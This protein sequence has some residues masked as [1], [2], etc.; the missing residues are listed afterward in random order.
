MPYLA[1]IYGCLLHL[2]V[3]KYVSKVLVY[4]VSVLG[5]SL[6]HASLNADALV[7]QPLASEVASRAVFFK[8][9]LQIDALWY[10]TRFKTVL[11]STKSVAFLSL[12]T[13]N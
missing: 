8:T 13:Y 4:N 3:G 11:E 7:V 9:Y 1:F 12:N 5:S 6:G 10:I 2:Y